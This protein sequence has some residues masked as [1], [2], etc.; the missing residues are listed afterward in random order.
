MKMR[1]FERNK[2]LN[3][4][5]CLLSTMTSGKKLRKINEKFLAANR[6]SGKQCRPTNLR[7]DAGRQ[8]G[9]DGDAHPLHALLVVGAEA[10]EHEAGAAVP[11]EAHVLQD[12][13]GADGEQDVLLQLQVL[14]VGLHGVL[15][16]GEIS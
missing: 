4:V 6:I 1:L 5:S 15:L 3:N 7:G 11:V 14:R 13:V 8:D 10:V 16:D 9:D 12:A 2:G